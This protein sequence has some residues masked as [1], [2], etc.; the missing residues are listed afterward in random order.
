MIALV[1]IDGRLVHGMVAVS[2]MG[3]VNPDTFVVVNDRAANDPFET[4]TLKLAKPANA[5]MF[6]WSKEKAV[7]RLN[8]GKYDKKK[9]FVIVGNVYD[10]KYLIDNVKGIGKLNVGPPLDEKSGRITEGKKEVVNV[11]I[12]PEEFQV[13]K[14]IH[15]KG[16]EVFAQI[17]PTVAKADYEEIAKKFE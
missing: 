11:Y 1:R 8:S 5:D 7:D 13:L 9:L 2:W 4:M 10:A 17:T 15:N 14:E 3:E 6:V 16:V 12:S